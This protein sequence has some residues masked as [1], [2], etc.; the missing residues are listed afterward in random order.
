MC[1]VIAPRSLHAEESAPRE[2]PP[3]V[4][5]PVDFAKDVKPILDRSCTQCHANGKRKGGFNIDHIHTFIGGG[6]SGPAVVT[7]K[8]AESLLIEL[9][10]T[11]DF[12]TFLSASLT[13]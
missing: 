4:S 8:S 11:T 3:A 12:E 7:G 5:R 13:S 9:R 10:C 1:T 2:L 6:D